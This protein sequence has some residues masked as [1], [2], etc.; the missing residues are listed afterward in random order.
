L[1]ILAFFKL[2]FVQIS[3]HLVENAI[4]TR[5]LAI[6]ATSIAFY[7]ILAWACAEIKIFGKEEKVTY[8]LRL[9]DF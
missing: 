3:F 5:Q 1:D 7:H 4:A 9:F 8:V 2:D 6:L